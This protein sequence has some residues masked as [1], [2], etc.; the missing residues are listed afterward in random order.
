MSARRREARQD[1]GSSVGPTHDL[2]TCL[3][4]KIRGELV[5]CGWV[6]LAFHCWEPACLPYVV[7]LFVLLYREMFQELGTRYMS[8]QMGAHFVTNVESPGFLAVSAPTG[9]QES[10]Y[11]TYASFYKECLSLVSWQK[12][13]NTVL[14]ELVK[15]FQG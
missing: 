1:P 9:G 3:T 8:R 7:T 13:T 11:S 5:P 15:L 10:S 12:A 6:S 4:Q 14:C 2:K